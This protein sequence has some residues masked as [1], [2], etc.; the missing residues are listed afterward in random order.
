MAIAKKCDV[1]KS[2]YDNYIVYYKRGNGQYN[3]FVTLNRIS[4][5]VGLHFD[6]CPECNKKLC[7]FLGLEFLQDEPK[8][9]QRGKD[10]GKKE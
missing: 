9:K 5:N 2:Y 1:C 6:L 8:T 7:D 10:G 3:G 4:E